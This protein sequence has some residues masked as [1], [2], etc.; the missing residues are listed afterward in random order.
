MP[1]NPTASTLRGIL[2]MLLAVAFFA[3]MDA[4]LKLFSTHYPAMQVGACLLYTSPSPR[5]RG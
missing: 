2:A 4:V 5:D 3:G 1:D